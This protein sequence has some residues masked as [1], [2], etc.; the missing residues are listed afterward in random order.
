MNYNNEYYNET[1]NILF[2][3]NNG[4][5]GGSK[6]GGEKHWMM[7]KTFLAYYDIEENILNENEGRVVW[8]LKDEDMKNME[9]KNKL[10]N[11]TIYL[12]KVRE[13]I[14]KNVPEGRVASY[15]NRFLLVDI[16]EEDAENEELNNILEEY[17]KP[18][19]IKDDILGELIYNKELKFFEGNIKWLEK[20]ISVYLDIKNPEDKESIIKTKKELLN[21]YNSQ[22]EKDNEFRKFA[23][24]ELIEQAND[25]NDE[26]IL[27]EEFVKRISLSELSISEDGDFVA[28]YNDDDIF[29]G[30]II[31]VYGNVEKGLE[32]ANMEG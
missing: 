23:A 32:S 30:H 18:I 28:Y 15:Y 14:D 19:I 6:G 8:Y 2:L 7:S 27:E 16:I 5:A 31:T 25:W 24:S 26:E 12:L 29:W 13:L 4:G 10:K 22:I 20:N 3:T 11:N 17:L 9:L 21:L 1:K